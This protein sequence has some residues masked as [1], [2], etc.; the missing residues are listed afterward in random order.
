MHHPCQAEA[1]PSGSK[2]YRKCEFIRIQ[3]INLLFLEH[4]GYAFSAADAHLLKG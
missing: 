4:E 2:K 1:E 3:Q